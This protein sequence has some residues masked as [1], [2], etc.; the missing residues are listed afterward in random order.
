M[1]STEAGHPELADS[2]WSVSIEGVSAESTEVR[3]KSAVRTIAVH[4][5]KVM[6]H[7]ELK[8]KAQMSTRENY[9]ISE[10]AVIEYT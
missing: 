2:D 5:W 8:D 9:W 4:Q 3:R 10:L 7:T 6:S 1:L